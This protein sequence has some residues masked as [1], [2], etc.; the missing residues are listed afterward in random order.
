MAIARCARMPNVSASS[1]AEHL[2]QKWYREEGVRR[3]G[4]DGGRGSQMTNVQV[5]RGM[6]SSSKQAQERW[7]DGR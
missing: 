3:G 1:S 5:L 7:V 6:S 2:Q 4:G